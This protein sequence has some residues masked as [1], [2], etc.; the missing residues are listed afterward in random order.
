MK[1]EVMNDKK[2]KMKR[3]VL[4]IIIIMVFLY[5]SLEMINFFITTKP[6]DYHY[7][8]NSFSNEIP[9]FIIDSK[10]AMIHP[11]YS[12]RNGIGDNV[13]HYLYGENYEIFLWKIHE[14]STLKCNTIEI[15]SN[16][17][18]V[19]IKDFPGSSIRVDIPS[20]NFPYCE[21]SL[22]ANNDKADE[23]EVIYDKAAT[24]DTQ[25][26]SNNFMYFSL[27]FIQ[28]VFFKNKKLDK[29][30][31]KQSTPCNVMLY[32]YEGCFYVIMLYTLD[33]SPIRKDMLLKIVQQ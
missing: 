22:L 3:V 6:F 17:D 28:M 12:W 21:I 11:E 20:E 14:Y 19:T 30:I 29:F 26:R 8:D 1:T 5:I 27:D 16:T 31:N 15:G 7:E 10:R 13:N 25:V 2:K 4:F 9:K 18:I 23:L 33:K 24:I 32:N